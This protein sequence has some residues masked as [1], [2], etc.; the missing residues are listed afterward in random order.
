MN[1]FRWEILRN[2]KSLTVWTGFLVLVQLMYNA[3]FPTFGNEGELFASKVKL[4]PKV[5][6]KV[7]GLDQIDFGDILH[8]FVMQGQVWVFLFATIYVLRL[9]SGLL[10]KEEQD[11]T[12]EFILTRPIT[13]RRY[14]FEKFVALTACIALFDLT[15]SVSLLLMLER[16]KTKPFDHGLF[17][18]VVFSFWGVHISMGAVGL[19]ASIVSRKRTTADGVSL[20]IMGCFY[21]L[22]LVGRV[23]ERYKLLTKFTPFGVFDPTALLKGASFDT[24][25]FALTVVAYVLVGLVG[26]RYYEG[27][28]IHT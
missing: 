18:A 20:L 26:A 15:L 11:G 2:S 19:L 1:I 24:R 10:A 3:L 7:F 21:A 22:A 17:W 23:F 16:F 13:R 4:L 27:K 5:F 28:D 8:F 12:I 9:S 25:A 6:L 14:V